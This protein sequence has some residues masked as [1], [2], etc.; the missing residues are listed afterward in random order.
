MSKRIK[1]LIISIVIIVTGAIITYLALTYQSSEDWLKDYLYEVYR[2]EQWVK[3]GQDG[4]YYAIDAVATDVIYEDG[5]F[6]A[7]K[8]REYCL[9][10]EREY[11]EGNDIFISTDKK[12]YKYGEDKI[13]F[14][15]KNNSDK[16][17]R[18]ISPDEYDIEVNVNGKWYAIYLWEAVAN[19]AFE[20]IYIKAGDTAEFSIPE[21]IIGLYK[22]AVT[23]RGIVYPVLNY[24]KLRPGLYRLIRRISFLPQGEEYDPTYITCTF[25]IKK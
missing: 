21:N 17:I 14:T 15:I 25:E 9:Q 16:T 4:K 10:P 1:I 20:G 3:V 8:T 12:V 2:G 11:Y 5:T 19:G 13:S 22:F 6:K 7:S 24:F 23:K 18:P